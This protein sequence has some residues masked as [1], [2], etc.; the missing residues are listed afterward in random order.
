MDEMLDIR[1]E[2]ELL[3]VIDKPIGLP[4]HKSKGMPHDAPYVTKLLGQ[5][6]GGSIY[7]VHRLDA[8]TSGLLLLART[9]EIANQLTGQF[10]NRLVGKTYIAIV[11]GTPPQEGTFDLPVRKA[12]KGKKAASV[13]HYELV[14]TVHTGWEHREEQ[15]QAI[16]LLQLKPETGRWHQLRQHC[17]QQRYDILG[18]PEHGDYAL[19]RL[20]AG[21]QGFK[22]LYLHAS[23]LRFTHPDTG[24]EMQ[25]TSDLP[26]T[27][28]ELLSSFRD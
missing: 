9:P 5:Q 10:A 26:S 7:N 21:H 14:E 11:K 20:I 22:R 16:S 17:A 23:A 12:R 28:E 8:K 4:V 6:L 18:D 25:L 27:F 19:N 2:D 13:T 1:Y 24:E 3:V 15:N